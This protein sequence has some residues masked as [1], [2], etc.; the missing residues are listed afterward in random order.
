MKQ[1]Q[2]GS[3]VPFMERYFEDYWVG[4]I[5]EFGDYLMTEEE[6]IEF[7]SKYDPQ[8][9]HLDREAAKASSFGT[10][11]SSGWHTVGVMMRLMVQNFI[12]PKS[13][14][15][16]PGVDQIRW[17]KPVK[18]GDRLRL[19]MHTTNAKKSSSKP[20]RGT[21][22]FETSVLNQADE[23][24]MTMQGLGMNRCKSVE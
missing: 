10:L 4:E 19:R 18:P 7:A 24:V 20:D 23:V 16:S 14:M 15:G 13:S 5:A 21:I 12:S 9:F 11:V 2:P 22:W 3:S 6:I 17:L 1:I 8:V